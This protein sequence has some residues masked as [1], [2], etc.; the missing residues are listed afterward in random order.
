MVLFSK[1][2]FFNNV[3]GGRLLPPSVH[4]ILANLLDSLVSH[5]GLGLLIVT[6]SVETCILNFKPFENF[7]EIFEF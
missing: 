5:L 4:L 3:H 1:E 6:W 2:K 7:N